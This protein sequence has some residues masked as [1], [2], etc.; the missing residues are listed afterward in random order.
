[1]VHIH[2]IVPLS[3]ITMKSIIWQ[4]EIENTNISLYK[5]TTTKNKNLKN[6]FGKYLK[7]SRECKG[8]QF[9]NDLTVAC[10]GKR[11]KEKKQS[12]PART[13]SMASDKISNTRLK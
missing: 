8:L 7:N 5:K 3:L 6:N 13:F 11:K 1:M 9:R 4:K 2:L 12:T 10:I